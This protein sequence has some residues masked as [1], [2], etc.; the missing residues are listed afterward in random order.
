MKFISINGGQGQVFDNFVA[1]SP[2]FVKFYSN[3]CGHCTDMAP[4]WAGLKNE[5]NKLGNLN[6]NIIEVE[7]SALSDI[8]SPC[9]RNI[10]GYP[11]IIQVLKNGKKGK[12]YNGNR[13]KEDMIKFI[14][15]TFKKTNSKNLAK[16]ITK[17]K[18]NN[19]KNKKRKMNTKKY[20]KKS[21]KGYTR[22]KK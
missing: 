4:A 12:E 7:A 22:G 13:S 16:G 5:L 2:A 15:K 17:R 18:N 21:N 19:R 8:K 9:A 1:D 6:A 10:E 11:T 14:N 20:N 3:G